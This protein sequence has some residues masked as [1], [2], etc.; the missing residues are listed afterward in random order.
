M[1]SAKIV[2][3]S[4]SSRGQRLTTLE[5]SYHRFIHSEFMTHRMFSRNATSSRAIPVSTMLSLVRDNPAIPIHW[6]KNQPGMQAREE[7]TQ[8]DLEEATERCFIAREKSGDKYADFPNWWYAFTESHEGFDEFGGGSFQK[9]PLSIQE[10]LYQEWVGMS[11]EA[12]KSAEELN[13]L[14][15]HKQ[16]VNRVLEPFQWIK[17]IVTATEW[18]NFFKLRLH[19]DAQPE[20][21]ELARCM[22]EAMNN[23]IPEVLQPGEWHLPYVENDS[24]LTMSCYGKKEHLLQDMIKCSVARCARV[25]YLNHNNSSPNVAK[26]VE[27][28]DQLLAAGHMSPF[29]HQGTPMSYDSEGYVTDGT[30]RVWQE[31]GGWDKGTTHMDISGNLW[32]GNFKSW[33]QNRQWK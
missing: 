19:P 29:E 20:I 7:L 10:V 26:D 3:D 11:R 25:S 15:L 21:Q 13:Q 24:V 18:D 6:G 1:I 2:A 22:Q 9:D 30:I 28:A 23:S 4:I 5:L 17:V 31:V 27:L 32:S 14:G 12:V 16:I 33:I 8:E